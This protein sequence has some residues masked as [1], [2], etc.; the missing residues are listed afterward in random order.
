VVVAWSESTETRRY[1]NR[2]AA[3]I[4]SKSIK[5]T[6]RL[7][8][9]SMPARQNDVLEGEKVSG[10]RL[11]RRTGPGA[12][13]RAPNRFAVQVLAEAA[14]T[15]VARQ[16]LGRQKNQEFPRS[17]SRKCQEEATNAAP[18]GGRSGEPE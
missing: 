3:P 1:S 2:S 7:F 12:Q 5:F 11:G 16:Y 13:A 17:R 10:C 9:K 8:E 6:R 4:L 14:A 15:L 18:S